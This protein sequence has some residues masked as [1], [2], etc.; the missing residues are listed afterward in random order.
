M[1]VIALAGKH[2]LIV[3]L[4]QGCVVHERTNVSKENDDN[5][6]VHLSLKKSWRR[7]LSTVFQFVYY[8]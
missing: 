4:M 3:S 2:I 6:F 7:R 8:V 1:I 5:A